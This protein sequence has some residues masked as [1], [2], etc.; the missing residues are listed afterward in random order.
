MFL[1][2]STFS[3]FSTIP[4]I[5]GTNISYIRFQEAFPYNWHKTRFTVNL[6]SFASRL[7]RPS[8][9]I[10]SHILRD[11]SDSFFNLIGNE[12]SSQLFIFTVSIVNS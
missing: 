2:F 3:T 10:L 4:T 6:I 5:F 12:A 1:Q 11:T 8:E 7:L 9:S